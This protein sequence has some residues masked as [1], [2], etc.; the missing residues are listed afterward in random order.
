MT[1][2]KIN[3]TKRVLLVA[4]TFFFY[5]FS[6]AQLYN[7]EVVA[8]INI[9]KN[10]E[11]FTFHASAENLMDSGYSLRYELMSFKT[12]ANNNT[13]KNTQ[14]NRFVLKPHEKLILSSISLNRNEEGKIILVMVIYDQDDKPISQ[15][16]VIL[17]YKGD[18]LEVEVL[19]KAKPKQIAISDQA[20]PQD[21]F[22]ISGLVIENTITKAGRD[23]YRYF[24]S[25]YRNKQIKTSKNILIEEV[26]AGFGIR[27]SKI[28]VKVDNQLVWQF[29]AQPKQDF[30]KKMSDLAMSRTI[31]KLQQIEKQKN[32]FIH[33]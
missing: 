10:S 32:N 14:G 12:D 23:F 28:S 3:I 31:S 20:K 11:F 21:G 8:K 33:Y 15:D 4:L 27:S 13:S 30:L 1:N 17:N 9:E 26:L 19:K 18:Q 24:Y 25:D 29:F 2:L 6:Y 22:V 5:N 16:R 7:K